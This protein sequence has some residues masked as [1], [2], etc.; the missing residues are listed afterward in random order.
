MIVRMFADAAMIQAA[1]I[2][3]LAARLT[4]GMLFDEKA[5]DVPALAES[6]V[7]VYLRTTWPLTLL[8]LVV[9][10]F[11]GFY[12][13]GRFY[14]GRFK[15][16]V[17]TQAV[18]QAYLI[19]G[20]ISYYVGDAAGAGQ[21]PFPRG[22]LLAAWVLTLLMIVGSRLWQNIWSRFV[23][24]EN[25][26]MSRL[27]NT[28]ENLVLVIGGAGYI[29]SAMLPK[30]LE[31]GY[32]VRLLDMLMFGEKP[33]EQF[34]DHPNLEVI[35]GDFRH[36]E[37]VVEAM[38]GV[39]SVVH[40]GAIVGDPACSLDEDLT[41]DVNLS[42][43]R[44]LAELAK[45]AGVERFVFASTCSVY[46]ACDEVLDEHSSCKPVSLYGHTKLASEKVLHRMATDQF[47]PTIVRFATIYG[48][49]GRTR[50]DLVVNVLSAKAKIDGVITIQG[51]DQWRPFVHVDDAARGVVEIL[52][53]PLELV[54]GQVFN[55][56]SNDQNYTITQIG[57]LVHQQVVTA[58]MEI[59]DEATDPRN[60]RVD[61]SKIRNLVGFS[62][63]WTV[64][65]GIQQVLEAIASGDVVDYQ[66]SRYSNLKSLT[67][68]GTS[69]FNR[70]GWAHELIRAAT[71]EEA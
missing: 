14:Q 31:R 34:L 32:K 33:I 21:L 30:L 56:G 37:N 69:S 65:E 66:D 8:A 45:A 2:A 10:Y 51:G 46:G 7:G 54:E 53:T 70:N 35:Q 29:G 36:V 25:E 13:Y 62:P 23:H 41:I 22:A 24:P 61:F 50:F 27:M 52:G 68:A 5:F 20:F 39:N 15:A 1:I 55:V 19:F 11:N 47:K 17:V 60:Y 9:F 18:C 57:E 64:E 28:D 16:F 3:S 67:E 6:Y 43:T 44:M 38:Q 48:F 63:Q 26:A 71:A 49:S 12:T 59:D 58:E 4:W 40:L 42:A